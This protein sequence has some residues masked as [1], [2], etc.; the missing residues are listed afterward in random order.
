L[1]AQSRDEPE[2][3]SSPPKTTVGVPC[4]DVLHRGV[5]D[6]Q[7]LAGGCTSVTAALHARAVGL[8]RQHEVLD[9]H[10]GERAAHHHL[11]VAARAP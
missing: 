2:P 1:A 7:L 5:V 6:R 8:R 3:Y 11:V 10:V 9:A 4:G